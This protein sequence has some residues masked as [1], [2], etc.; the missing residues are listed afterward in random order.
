MLF[1]KGT[2]VHHHRFGRGSVRLD[3]GESIL[4]R[5]DHGVEEC[6]PSDLKIVEALLDRIADTK[7][8]P[9]VNVISRVLANCIV[10]VNDV[11][12]VFSRSKIALLPHQL[13]VCRK[14]LESWPTRWLIADDVGLGKTIEAGL[15]LSPLLSSGRVRRLL[16]LAPASLVDQWQFRMREMFDIRLSTYAPQADTSKSYYWNTHD[17]VIA[18]SHTLRT[19][20]SGRWDRL[21]NSSSWDLVIVDEAHHMN[22]DEDRGRT[23]SF[24]V[25]EKLQSRNLVQSLILFTGTPHRGKD[26]GFLSLLKLL[27]PSDFD[28]EDLLE[29]QVQKLRK[30][31]IR[32]NKQKVTDMKG[33]PL[34]TTVFQ[35]RETYSY[36]LEESEFYDL[37]TDFI[38][39]GKAY[40]ASLD[41]NKRR[42]V[43]LLLITMQKLASSSVAAVRKALSNRLVELRKAKSKKEQRSDD[44][45]KYESLI[46]EDNSANADQI[47]L[48]EERL[49]EKIG[50]KIYLNPDEIPA[51]EELLKVADKVEYETK[52]GRILEVIREKF[53]EKSI[54]F[55]TEYKA[56]QALLMNAL[57]DRYGPDSTTFING[58]GFLEGVKTSSGTFGLVKED[59]HQAAERFNLGKVRF[60]VSTEAAGEG[61]DLQE[62]CHTL[63]H[64]D[65]PWN[66]MR[67][68][69]RVGRVSRYGQTKPVD[70]VTVRN[71][72][73]IESRIWGCL[74]AKLDRIT[75]A[76]QGAMDDP[77]DMRQLVIGMASPRMFT[78][79]FSDADP[80]LRGEMLDQWFNA[81]T[82]TFGEHDAVGLV[83]N[84]F[85]NVSRFDFG[86]DA[87][88]IPKVDLPDLVPFCK[89]ILAVLGK[90]PTQHDELRLSLKTPPQW[91]DDFTLADRYALLF[92]RTNRP[93]EKEEIAGVGMKL[94]DKAIQTALALPDSFASISDLTVPLMIFALRDRITGT[95]GVVRTITAGVQKN[96]TGEMEILR[97]WQI[98]KILNLYADKPRSQALSSELT[99]IQDIPNLL[100]EAKEFLKSN[101]DMLDLPFRLPEID[102]I[103]CIVPEKRST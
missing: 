13:W 96:E 42:M 23:L 57:I 93:Q 77:E 73:T 44:L 75:L 100:F 60:L 98:I 79:V 32:N 62:S 12:G 41:Q 1:S 18:S 16:I 55:F 53:P 6:L 103:G 40:A 10:S 90:R 74:D 22:V 21:L 95:E 5:F 35:H 8:D 7:L 76:F 71:P 59:R 25:V 48:L 37:L 17:K 46:S 66:P 26:F 84:L 99:T 20:T 31:M 97:D 52:I 92:T 33:K 34:F 101:L 28:P 88:Q 19:D 38:I 4:V 87:K 83:K 54:L 70:V 51:L 58:D 91:S 9:A 69:Q 80:E 45:K 11:W 47:S 85:G 81:K 50:N 72:D 82:A 27:R 102:E 56:T 30:V 67:L 49:A 86:E 63:I 36:S 89:S 64:V 24:E 2:L 3:D 68:H 14:V 15:I 78:D 29:N 65:L 61:I 94:V 39:T 43:F